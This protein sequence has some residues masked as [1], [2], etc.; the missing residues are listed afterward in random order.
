M[1]KSRDKTQ[2]EQ[3]DYVVELA[4][5]N[6]RLCQIERSTIMLMAHVQRQEYEDERLIGLIPRS[7]RKEF[8]THVLPRLREEKRTYRDRALIITFSLN[9]DSPRTDLRVH[10][11]RRPVAKKGPWAV[12]AG[13]A[14]NAPFETQ[15]PQQV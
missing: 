10:E 5:E 14:R 13:R 12:A 4:T 6:M 11:L 3:F 9:W 15:A 8:K 1:P 2:S 7:E